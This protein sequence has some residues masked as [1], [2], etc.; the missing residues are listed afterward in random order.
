M[1]VE[2]QQVHSLVDKL[3]SSQL[4]AVHSLLAV[5]LDPVSRAIANAPLDDETETGEERQAVAEADEWLKHNTPI[6][7]DD[8][9]ADFRLTLEDVK[10]Y[11]EPK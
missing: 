10:N 4:T 6:P 1:S 5:M 3:A 9:L 11:K 8:V 2:R 7:F